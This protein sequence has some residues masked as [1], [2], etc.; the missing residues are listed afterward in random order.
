[1]AVIRLSSMPPSANNLFATGKGGRRFTSKR[2]Q[3]WKGL[4]GWELQAQR[5]APARRPVEIII[6]L[7]APSQAVC[8]RRKG[9]STRR[10]DADNYIKPLVD[11]LVRHDVLPDDHSGWVKKVSAEWISGQ[12]DVTVRLVPRTATAARG[13]NPG[14]RQLVP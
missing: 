3:Q 4:A 1:M 13:G 7:P 10:R 9:T 12:T 11:L 5:P 14:G 8:K 2:Y 6:G